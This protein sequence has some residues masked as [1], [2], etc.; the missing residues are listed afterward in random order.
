MTAASKTATTPATACE[1]FAVTVASRA[2]Q[3]ALRSAD[4]SVDWSWAEYAER[5]C[6]AGGGLAGLGVGRGDTVAL[7]LTNRP[8]FHV[9]D[10]G[11]MLLGAAPFSVYP[12][13]TVEQAEHVIGDAGARVLVTEPAFLERALAVRDS[14]RTAVETVVLVDGSHP[15]A[16]A[17]Q[18]LLDLASEPLE[19]GAAASHAQPDDLVTLIYTSGTTGPPKGVQ[20]T[21]RNVTSLCSAIRDHAGFPEGLRAVSYLPMAHIAERIC[22]HYEP[23]LLGWEVTTCPDP[24][25]VAEV[26]PRVRPGFFF[27]PP[28]LWEKMR[29]AVLA[30]LERERDE[31]RRV[32][33]EQAI[34]AAVAKVRLE[35]A[36]E[37]VPD[38]LAAQVAGAEAAFAELRE[39]LG[40]DQV[41]VAIVG[42]APCPP[43]VIE[44]FHAIGVPLGE[45]YGMSETTGV[46]T[47][48]PPDAIRI[49]TVGTSLP[50]VET[51]LSDEGEILMRGPNVMAGYRNLPSKT[52]EV[53]DSDGWL[54]SGDIGEF[55]EG[56]YLRI[57]DRIKEL[58]I[59]A[60][61]KNMSPANIEAKLKT[62]SE[63]IGLACAVGDGRPYNVALITLDPDALA[64]FATANGIEEASV[65]ALTTHQAVRGEVERG[66]ERANEQLARVEQIKRFTILPVEWQ[67]GDELT[68][69]MK[70]KRKPIA[71]KF[72]AEID[73]LYAG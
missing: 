31:E 73:A 52:A 34:D 62:S 26:L 28:R 3:R 57:I 47:M 56:G 66:V 18:E 2:D 37:P 29:A 7:W 48:N 13:F 70:L 35:Q 21:H 4:G 54:H 67:P 59:S 61:G 63:L 15:E 60:A 10:V 38:E 45:V 41:Q 6:A 68:P 32:G 25:A 51:R 20:L 58:I 17:W 36:G 64:A 30:G 65:E 8:E 27:S 69:T 49:G 46:Q 23:M 11:A 33:A 12:T 22:T 16:I 43:E 5:A 50:G 55:D 14:G 44:F 39:R 53:I 1:A 9:A 42:A 40:L 72:A 19:L 24:R 71:D